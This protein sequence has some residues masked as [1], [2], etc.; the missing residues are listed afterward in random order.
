MSSH[1]ST[2]QTERTGSTALDWLTIAIGCVVVLADVAVAYGLL[3]TGGVPE[4]VTYGGTAVVVAVVGGSFG[5]VLLRRRFGSTAAPDDDPSTGTRVAQLVV[6]VAV[7]TGV[8]TILG[9]GG[10]LVLALGARLGGPDPRTADGDLLRDRLLDWPER[11]R[12]FMRRNGR[13]RLPLRP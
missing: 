8:S 4:V 6:S 2:G 7:V 12:E 5:F 11:N 3:A 10:G 1:T 9:Y 13:G